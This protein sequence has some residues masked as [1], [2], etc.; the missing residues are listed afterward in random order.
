MKKEVKKIT[1][2][3][4]KGIDFL[5]LQHPTFKIPK[6]FGQK[7]ADSITKWAGSWTFIL[8]FL[9]SFL[10][11]NQISFFY[12]LYIHFI[13]N[14]YV[15]IV[16]ASLG[17]FSF[18]LLLKKRIDMAKSFSVLVISR[19]IS[20]ALI[21]LLFL[22]SGIYLFNFH[23]IIALRNNIFTLLICSGL[24]LLIILLVVAFRIKYKIYIQNVIKNNKSFNKQGNDLYFNSGR[25]GLGTSYP[26]YTLDINGNINVTGNFYKNGNLLLSSSSESSFK[27]GQY[28]NSVNNFPFS[29]TTNLGKRPKKVKITKTNSQ[30][31]FVDIEDLFP[32]V[33]ITN[34][35]FGGSLEF[36]FDWWGTPSSGGIIVLNDIDTIYVTAET[37]YIH[38]D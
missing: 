7:A 18:P 32:G 26:N 27:V 10:H 24:T 34:V 11:Q 3:L 1:N 30:M 17:E 6:T 12:L 8:S 35:D 23:R 37:G 16:P 25:V 19:I 36:M 21:F 9:F 31:A 38:N 28:A 29:I 13:Q 14:F 4:K 2:P 5:T 15:H 33:S 22:T 20:L